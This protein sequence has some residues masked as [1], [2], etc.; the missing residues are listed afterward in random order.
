IEIYNPNPWMTFGGMG[1]QKLDAPNI[2]YI[3]NNDTHPFAQFSE[4]FHSIVKSE[5]AEF[6]RWTMC[7]RRRRRRSNHR[8]WPS[9]RRRKT[10]SR[11]PWHSPIRTRRNTSSKN[12]NSQNLL[13]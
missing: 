6:P 10:A 2:E 3:A 7:K 4:Q 12:T 9:C 11:P 1:S 8:N 5:L 13:S